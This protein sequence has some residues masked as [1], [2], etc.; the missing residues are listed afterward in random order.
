MKSVVICGSQRYKE[1]IKQF[2]QQLKKLGV[3]V[4]FEPNFDRQRKE[5]WP[6]L[7]TMSFVPLKLTLTKRL[8]N[9][10]DTGRRR[11]YY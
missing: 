10:L 4:V 5:I 8:A 9:A 6:R 11:R 2:S 3:S 7:L 1:D